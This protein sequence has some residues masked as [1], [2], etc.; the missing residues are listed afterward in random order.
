MSLYNLRGFII[1]LR[2]TEDSCDTPCIFRW[3]AWL[4]EGTPKSPPPQIFK[5]IGY[6]VE[7]EEVLPGQTL[8]RNIGYPEPFWGHIVTGE[9][10]ELFWPGAKYALWA[11]GT[12]R[13]H[14]DQ[15]IG[16]NSGL[17]P[18][19]IPGGACCYSTCVEVEEPSDSEPDDPRVEK[20]ARVPGTPCISVSLQGPS[21]ISKTEKICITVKIHYD[22]LTNE[23]HEA[24]DADA[25]P[26]I[27]HDYPFSSDNFR[28]KIYNDDEQNPGWAIADE[29]DVEVNV[30]D[31]KFPRSL[32]IGETIVRHRSL[33]YFDLH[34]D[35]VVGD[36]YRY[37][38]WGGF[39]DW[40]TVVKLPCWLNDHVVE[41]ESNDGRPGIMVP[42]SNFVEFTVV[43]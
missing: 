43:D 10:Y 19:I 20:S 2:R 37:Q 31:A 21:R 32:K 11:W 35:A 38:Y 5:L 33:G 6:E 24:I 36:T 1:T 25:K 42:A 29:T 40:W 27:I 16:V 23:D 8:R 12:L 9:K 4:V 13:E 41:P 17:P 22:R 28:C 39:I 26:I 30:A 34:P 18:V 15:E 14:W 3:N 7:T